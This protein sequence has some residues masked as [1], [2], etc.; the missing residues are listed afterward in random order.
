M[1]TLSS[2]A[3]DAGAPRR[4][5]TDVVALEL[6]ANGAPVTGAWLTAG[7]LEGSLH[8]LPGDLIP[9]QNEAVLFIGVSGL[10]PMTFPSLGPGFISTSAVINLGQQLQ[11]SSL[12]AWSP[13]LR[14]PI[15]SE[16][17][18][19][20][21]TLPQGGGPC[22]SSGADGELRLFAPSSRTCSTTLSAPNQ[23]QRAL[24]DGAEL[25]V[26]TAALPPMPDLALQKMSAT[27]TV[28]W[29]WRAAPPQASAVAALN[30]GLIRRPQ[31]IVAFWL[32]GNGSLLDQAGNQISCPPS[33]VSRNLLV[34]RHRRTDG[35]L[36]WFH[37]FDGAEQQGTRPF[38]QSE[39]FVSTPNGS[40]SLH[41]LSGTAR[42]F[43]ARIGSTN[44]TGSPSDPYFLM[45]L[46]FPPE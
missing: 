15:L 38:T 32:A 8:P 18:P 25:V 29:R 4:A 21:E 35:A 33:P 37:C 24:A 40:L 41:R 45:Q 34:T 36:T 28:V 13:L 17:G 14:G 30:L 42:P 20:M 11:A 7:P 31:S 46:T 10:F 23:Y 12:A 6:N 1:R 9:D 44:V 22:T 5:G 16:S 43:A 19:W 26:A 27:G 3:F 39:R 2:A